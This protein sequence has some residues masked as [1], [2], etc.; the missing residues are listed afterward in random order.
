[1][2]KLSIYLI[3][4]IL[5]SCSEGS[6]ICGELDNVHYVINTYYGNLEKVNQIEYYNAADKILRSWRPTR[7]IKNYLYDQEGRLSQIQYSRSC[8]LVM[9]YQYQFYNNN[10]QLVYI[11]KSKTPITNLDSITVIPTNFYNPE[12][13]IERE[14]VYEKGKLFK[15]SYQY[16]LGNLS[17]EIKENLNGDLIE[18]KTYFY[19]AKNQVDSIYLFNNGINTLEINTYDK[20][21]RI[22]TKS[23]KT[24][25]TFDEPKLDAM[26]PIFDNQNHTRTY[27]YKDN[28]NIQIE[29]RLRN[30]G[31]SHLTIIKE[32]K[33]T[34]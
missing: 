28:G 26:Q 24:K 29:K 12:G 2:K 3:F 23:S 34:T 1:M 17:L 27:E 20:Q 6:E 31:K 22:I 25:I 13:K 8:A 33:Y 11:H 10:D 18:S 5:I 16:K 32:K 4:M 21:G 7:E 9:E 30:D 19:D 14:I 15:K